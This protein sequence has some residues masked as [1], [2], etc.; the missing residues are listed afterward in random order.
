MPNDIIKGHKIGISSLQQRIKARQER[1]ET[2]P[3]KVFSNRI[4][5]LLDLSGSMTSHE[6]GKAKIEHLK[7]ALE[8][9]ASSLDESNTSVCAESFPSGKVLLP[10][11]SQLN[12]KIFAFSLESNGGTPLGA[13]M[14]HALSEYSITNG[15]VIS[16]GQQTDG[17]RCF[18]E[19]MN[20]AEARIPLDCLHIGSS[21]DGEETLRRIAQATNGKYIKFSDVGNFA[22]SL[23]YL[24]P[25]YRA[26]LESGDAARL[27]GAK[28]VK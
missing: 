19:A 3:P 8:G 6:N 23:K 22:K 18:Q 21:R 2:T 5:L 13:A 27:L 15:I 14:A 7:D 20:Y 11:N 9:F 24:L 10:T 26:M 12:L 28:E 16:D 25:A 17:D 4:L 1:V